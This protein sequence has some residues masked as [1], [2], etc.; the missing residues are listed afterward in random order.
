MNMVP[1]S[2]SFPHL[3]L[4]GF[5]QVLRFPGLV[6]PNTL[7]TGMANSWLCC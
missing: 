4:R 1:Q 6:G 2:E 5:V 3:C 7:T